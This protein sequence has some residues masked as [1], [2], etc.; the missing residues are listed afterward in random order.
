MRLIDT[1]STITAI[2]LV[3]AALSCSRSPESQLKEMGFYTI[4]DGKTLKLN[5]RT[6][7]A[8]ASTAPVP[9]LKKGRDYLLLFG[10][11]P[12]GAMGTGL[13]IQKFNGAKYDEPTA[14]SSYFVAV[15]QEPIRGQPVIKYELRPETVPGFYRL[16]RFIGFNDV[17]TH[18]FS[19]EG[20]SDALTVS[21]ID[22]VAAFVGD[23]Y[24]G[25]PDCMRIRAT[26]EPSV[27]QVAVGYCESGQ[28]P[29]VS[30]TWNGNEL[31]GDQR[32]VLI[33]I[34]DQQVIEASYEDQGNRRERGHFKRDKLR[35]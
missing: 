9:K 23:W 24:D 25:G 35:W 7:G 2:G 31:K 22:P 5:E 6:P 20:D 28:P 30:A 11:L 19:I 34:V 27:F 16:H 3:I 12:E 33:R 13:N 15:P 21:A 18:S 14:L 10:P 17:G 8:P 4:I 1:R 32:N 26:Q 29:W